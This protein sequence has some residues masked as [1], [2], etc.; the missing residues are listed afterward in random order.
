MEEDPRYR[1]LAPAHLGQAQLTEIARLVAGLGAMRCKVRD[2]AGAWYMV[3]SPDDF[4]G[5]LAG[6]AAEELE[7]V[8]VTALDAGGRPV[9]SAEFSKERAELRFDAGN[10]AARVAADGIRRVC[11]SSVCAVT[12]FA[13][14][15]QWVRRGLVAAPAAGVSV[16]YIASHGALVWWQLPAAVLVG[17][18]LVAGR[19]RRFLDRRLVGRTRIYNVPTER[20]P[21]FLARNKD[22]LFFVALAALFLTCSGILLRLPAWLS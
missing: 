2:A 10:G 11:R 15:H 18:L 21:G 22:A 4:A 9:I 3:T 8:S 12:R 20:R 7:Y 1:D 6:R 5:G 19:A 16:G 13:I 14:D 17:A